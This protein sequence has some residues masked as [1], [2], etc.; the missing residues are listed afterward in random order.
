MTKTTL[1]IPVQI[2]SN[3]RLVILRS[4]SSA[5]LA[6]VLGYLQG[7]QTLNGSRVP[8]A[9]LEDLIHVTSSRLMF[10]QPGLPRR[11]ADG[12]RLPYAGSI[13]PESPMWMGSADQQVAGSGPPEITTFVGNASSRL[14]TAQ[15]GDYFDNGAIVHLSHVIEDLGQFYARPDKPYLTY[16]KRVQYMFRSDPIPS[17]GNADQFR[18]GGSPSCFENTFQ[19]PGDAASNAQGVNT[20]QGERRTGHLAT[21]HRSSR[22]ADGTPIHIRA[23][24]PG[25]DA[26][27]VPDGTS[28]PKLQ[29]CVFVPSADFF[30]TMRRK[31]ASLDLVNRYKVDPDDKRSRALHHRD[32]P[33]ELRRTAQASP[34]VS[35]RG[36][37]LR[38]RTHG[39][40]S[41][42]TVA[43]RSMPHATQSPRRHTDAVAEAAWSARGVVGG[44]PRRRCRR[45]RRP[46]RAGRDRDPT[47]PG[48]AHHPDSP[49]PGRSPTPGHDGP[50]PLGAQAG[51]RCGR[52][53]RTGVGGEQ[54]VSRFW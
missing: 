4:D 26:L 37:R 27:D 46:S 41:T 48:L 36:G 6:D 18:D 49:G 3:H 10:T 28:Q 25:F 44:C 16:T 34:G 12:A 31:Q 13:N 11:L 40:T 19:G 53:G 52:P 8:S 32:P 38:R 33:A 9:G 17:V 51:A 43:R 5:I 42:S 50:A 20:Y 2:E 24:G 39:G 45:R 14:T 7:A 35:P 54:V 22:A 30:A 1:N 21:L 47:R 29:F 15:P 23:D